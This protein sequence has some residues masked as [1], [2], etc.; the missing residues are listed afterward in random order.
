MDIFDDKIGDR[1]NIFDDKYVNVDNL[2]NWFE[3]WLSI[4]L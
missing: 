1:V 4:R 2:W 3:Y